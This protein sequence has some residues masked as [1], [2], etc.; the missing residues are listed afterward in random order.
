L[1]AGGEVNH[2]QPYPPHHPYKLG[3]FLGY[4][5]YNYSFSVSS[6]VAS[7]SIKLRA[8][9]WFFKLKVLERNIAAA[10]FWHQD[11]GC[12]GKV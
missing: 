1:I 2:P 11:R 9:G 4:S 5:I 10:L 3:M 8:Q 12:C 6:N 7:A